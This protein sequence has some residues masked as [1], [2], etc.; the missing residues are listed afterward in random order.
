MLGWCAEPRGEACRY[1]VTPNVDHAVMF[2]HRA[3]LRAA[4]ADASL[5]LADGAP[6]VVASRLLRKPLPERVAGSDLVPQLFAAGKPLRV[7][8]LGAAPGVADVAAERIRQQW[9]AIQ[10]VGTYSPPLGFENDAAENDRILAA[11]AA[12]APDLLIVGFGAPKQELWVHRHHRQLAGEGRDLCRRDDRLPGRPSPA[13]AGVDATRR[14]R[15]AAPRRQRAAP[16]GR[17]LRPRRLGVSRSSSGANGGGSIPD[18][19]GEPLYSLSCLRENILVIAVDGLRAAALGAYGNTAYSDP[20]PRP[21]RRRIAAVRLVLCRRG[22]TAADLSLAVA[23]GEIRSLESL[24]AHGLRDDAR[25]RR[26][27]DLGLDGAARLSTNACKLPADRRRREPKTS[28]RR[29][30]RDCS[31]RCANEIEATATASVRG[32]FGSIPAACTG[33]GTRRWSCR[34][35]C[36]SARKA[37]RRP[38]TRS[39]RPTWCSTTPAIPTRRFAG[40]APTRRK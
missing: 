31:R 39:N 7:F 17:P 32:W 11:V 12:A 33:R 21:A 26:A 16:A 6:L 18:A 9:P 27:G 3:D 14:P 23:D 13:F 2:Q 35:R 24:A 30:S 25:D 15:M 34:S 40:A 22:R 4:Y 1:V 8:L 37:I 38:P 20:G 29:R 19:R 36:W 10:V 5:V 28:R